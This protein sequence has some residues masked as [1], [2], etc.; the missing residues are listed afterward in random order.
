[1]KTVILLVFSLSAI[2]FG[3]TELNCTAKSNVSLQADTAK[4]RSLATHKAAPV[5]TKTK[6]EKQQR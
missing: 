6:N 1:M 5:K 3:R 4:V 2:A